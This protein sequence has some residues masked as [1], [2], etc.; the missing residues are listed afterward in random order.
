MMGAM[1]G[2]GD[3]EQG[4]TIVR[5]DLGGTAAFAVSAV[6]SAVV[7]TS[8]F[9][10][11]A[12]VVALVLFAIGV[13]AFLWSYWTAVQRSRTD[14]IAVAQLYFLASGSTPKRVKLTM[15]LALLVQALV[16]LGTAIARSTTDGRAGS[17]L[18]F[19]ILVPM[20]GLGLNG[21]WCSKFGH[22][23][24]RR[25]ATASA[26]TEPDAPGD[27]DPGSVR[28]SDHQMEQNSPHG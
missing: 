21:L 4:R 25:A 3:V 26:A 13:F 2:M 18:A 6:A 14:N 19:G 22:F 8:T 9:R 11:I 20:F 24:P 28:N 17:T 16:G 10:V 1:A 23:A 12:V 7:F 27:V 15:N 5:L